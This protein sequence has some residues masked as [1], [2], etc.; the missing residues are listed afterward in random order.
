M[1]ALSRSI[2]EGLFSLIATFEPAHQAAAEARAQYLQ[3]RVHTRAH[4]HRGQR[5]GDEIGKRLLFLVEHVVIFEELNHTTTSY[6]E[7]RALKEAMRPFDDGATFRTDMTTQSSF[8]RY[9]LNSFNRLNF[10][11]IPY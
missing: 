10:L 9:L 7:E 3:G 6:L 1:V 8:V 2:A 4:R 11:F 5:K